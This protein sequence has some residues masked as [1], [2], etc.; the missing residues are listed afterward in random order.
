MVAAIDQGTTSTRCLLFA[1]D[2]AIVG[3]AQLEHRQLT[4]RPGWVEHDAGEIW[5]RAA[6]VIVGAL[7]NGELDAKDVAAV[8]I[9]NQ[10]ETTVVWDPATGEPLAPA[11]VWQD[12]RTAGLAAALEDSVGAA[13]LRELTGLP[14]ATYFSGPKLR[15][16]LDHQEGLRE[17]ARAGRAVFGTVESWLAWKLTGGAVHRTDATN[18]SRTLMMDLGRLRWSDELIDALD[19]PASML[20]EITPSSHPEAWGRTLRDG[21]FGA[22][23]PISGVIGDQQAALLGQLRRR[24]G[25]AKCT[26]GTGAFLLMH[27]GAK[28]IA[29]RAGLLTTV[30]YSDPEKVDYALEGSVAVAGSLVQWLRDQLGFG[31]SASEVERLAL[32]VDDSGGAV[33][34]PAFSGLFAP[35]WRS[36]A[37]GVIC[38]LTRHTDRRHLARAAIEA[39]AFQVREVIEAMRADAGHAPGELRVDGGMTVSGLLLAFQADILG[40]PVVRPRCVETTALGAAV[41]AGLSVGFWE[42]ETELAGALEE[43]ARFEPTMSAAERDERLTAWNKAVER[44]FDWVGQDAS[45]PPPGS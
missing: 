36:D 39:S 1:R 22:S 45:R 4:P 31:A 20:P 11:I 38:G 43:E 24:P 21:P 34:V 10:R 30:A 33:I 14:A 9:T 17:R 23:L 25:E 32:Q 42:S 12:T 3:A 41:A 28:A 2:G 13:R 18:A 40:I 44:S 27:T 29:S 15:W 7:R 26:Y 6:D 37:R 19:V 5:D 8:G 16:L 35:W